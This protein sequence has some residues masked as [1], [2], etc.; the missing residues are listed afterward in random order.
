[1]LSARNE[2]DYD[3]YYVVGLQLRLSRLFPHLLFPLL[4]LSPRSLSFTTTIAITHSLQ[5]T[6][7]PTR[8]FHLRGLRNPGTSVRQT[9]GRQ[10]LQRPRY[11]QGTQGCGNT[12][13]QVGG[14]KLQDLQLGGSSQLGRNRR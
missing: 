3:A 2:R 13:R 8:T 14:L 6:R 12:T 4:I 1:M 5:V 10:I 9:L 7:T 11:I